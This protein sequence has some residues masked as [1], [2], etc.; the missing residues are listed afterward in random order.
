MVTVVDLRQTCECSP[1]Q[2]EGRTD[3][4]RFVYVRYRWGWLQVGFGATLEDAVADDETYV[5]QLGHPMDG[6][7]TYVQLVA[8]VP[9]VEW[10]C[11]ERSA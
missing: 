9:W 10:P 4:G 6:A 8:A 7:L 11:V 1:S 3:D 2:W 5:R